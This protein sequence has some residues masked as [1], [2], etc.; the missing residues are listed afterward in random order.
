MISRKSLFWSWPRLL[1]CLLLVF[2]ADRVRAVENEKLT[3]QV[4][5]ATA[6]KPLAAVLPPA[7]WQQV[8]DSVDRALVWIASQ[9]AADG[10][11]PTLAQGQPAVTS[12]CVMAFLSRGHQ[13]NLGT[14]GQ[15][16]NRAI[17]YVLSCQASN[18]LIS[19]QPP[20]PVYEDKEAS[21]TAVY[22][23]AISGLMLG[24]VYGQV[25]GQRARAA[26]Q[27]IER[28][29]QFSRQLQLRPKPTA[30]RGGWRYIRINSYGSG[31][32]SDLSV[33]GWQLMF[34][35]SARNAEFEVP[36]GYVDEATA[37]VRSIWDSGSGAFYYRN[38]EDVG[39]KASRGMV[40]AGILC[41]SL[42][43]QHQT[44]MALAAGDWLLAHPYKRFGELVSARD[45]FFYG[46]YYCSQAMA[47]LGGRYWEQFFP[48]LANVLLSSQ[49][50][51]GSWPIE[52]GGP[53]GGEAIFGNVYTT[54]MAVLSLTPPYQLLPVYQR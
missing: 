43:G 49:A 24:E 3:N 33:T 38:K 30:D 14:Y 40:G 17:D 28:A 9:Q 10:S 2:S 18:G 35:R 12:L 31:V 4:G 41:L 29:L 26:K 46:A 7:N 13:P 42:G 15:R 39:E 47:Q 20:G 48:P 53:L 37:Y 8:E 54:A 6:L 32:D 44:R 23:H 1:F 25:S 50:P 5:K 19:F 21:H 34:M 36:Q 52:V 45:R 27:T 51:D 22:N 16:L 11:F